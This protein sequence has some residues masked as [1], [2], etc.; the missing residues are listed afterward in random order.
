MT[1]Y[2]IEDASGLSDLWT[3]LR[4][5]EAP[6]TVSI[7][8]GR[9]RSTEQNRLQRLWMNEISEQLSNRTPEG[10]RGYSKLAFG[11]PILKEGSEVIAEKF[12]STFDNLPY[13]TR[14]QLMMEPFSMPVTRTMTTK[15]K[16]EYLDRIVRHFGEKGVVLTMPEGPDNWGQ[17]R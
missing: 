7:A 15:Q 2:T 17:H 14:L 8:K 5:T 4:T 10:W 12:A 16:T 9:K 13:E 1:S 11:V 3:V 6:F